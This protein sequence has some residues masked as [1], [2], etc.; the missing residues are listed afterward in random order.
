MDTDTKPWK[1]LKKCKESMSKHYPISSL[2]PE[3]CEQLNLFGVVV[4]AICGKVCGK[5]LY[6][7]QTR[8]HRSF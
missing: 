2:Y 8:A 3:R 1:K 7:L 6:A 4:L 5:G